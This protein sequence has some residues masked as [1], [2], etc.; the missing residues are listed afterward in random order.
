MLRVRVRVRV[1]C[2]LDD[3]ALPPLGCLMLARNTPE[4][5]IVR[6]GLKVGLVT[7][8]EPLLT[9]GGARQGAQRGRG[10]S[11]SSPSCWYR[12]GA[13]R[14]HPK[15]P[16]LA[17]GR[18]VRVGLKSGRERT[19]A[20]PRSHAFPKA[21]SLSLTLILTC[22]LLVAVLFQC[23]QNPPNLSAPSQVEGSS[24]MTRAAHARRK[25]PSLPVHP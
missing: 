22:I 11:P 25:A 12:R 10:Q 14:D 24:N 1:R 23:R 7:A 13:S 16:P 3:P 9:V 2:G 4:E 15:V 20:P 8:R 21:N 18:R 5:G 19:C 17:S 6:R